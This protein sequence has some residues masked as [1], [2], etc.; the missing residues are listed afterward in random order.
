M[1]RP[2][3]VPIHIGAQSPWRVSPPAQCPNGRDELGAAVGGV[4]ET[5]GGCLDDG[6]GVRCEGVR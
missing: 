6:A 2:S 3:P 5:A 4:P 1:N